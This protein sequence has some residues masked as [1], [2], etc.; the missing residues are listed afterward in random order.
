LLAINDSILFLVNMVRKRNKLSTKMDNNMG[1]TNFDRYIENATNAIAVG[2]N[3]RM[4][5]RLN[6]SNDRKRI[7]S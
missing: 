4:Q 3:R 5:L 2:I 1:R 7:S 6:L